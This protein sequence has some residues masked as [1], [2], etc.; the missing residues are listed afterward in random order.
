MGSGL[1]DLVE[2]RIRIRNSSQCASFFMTRTA[3]K[4]SKLKIFV[5][6]HCKHTLILTYIP[7]LERTLLSPTYKLESSLPQDY[8]IPAMQEFFRQRPRDVFQRTTQI[9]S[10]I[11]QCRIGSSMALYS[12]STSFIICVEFRNTVVSL[13]GFFRATCTWRRAPFYLGS[14]TSKKSAKNFSLREKKNPQI[15]KAA[16]PR[17]DKVD[18]V[19]LM[20][21]MR[22]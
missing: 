15:N 14:L 4:W 13:V 11:G 18:R 2:F 3:G 7:A 6:V 1:I 16:L 19:T 5:N 17:T 12:W 8:N 20:C 21:Y 10:E 22:I 9:L